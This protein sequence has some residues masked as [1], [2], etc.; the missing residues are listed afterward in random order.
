[1]GLGRTQE[2]EQVEER[3]PCGHLCPWAALFPTTWS[4]FPPDLYTSHRELYL[5]ECDQ[6]FHSTPRAPTKTGIP[7]PT[8]GFAGLV[9]VFPLEWPPLKSSCQMG[10]LGFHLSTPPT[11]PL[12]P[13]ISTPPLCFC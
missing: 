11:A 7:E 4:M 3:S 2:M 8:G 13:L 1:M 10:Q 9:Q 6:D 12:I 5:V